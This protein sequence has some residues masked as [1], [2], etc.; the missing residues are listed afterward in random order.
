V[1]KLN[2]LYREELNSTFER[3]FD[4]VKVLASARPLPNIA[5]QKVK[6]ALS[7]E[8]TYN[9]NSI[10][11]N[12][13]SLRET[14]MVLQEG[15]TVKGKSLRE[16]FEAKNHETA[17]DYLYTLVGSTYQLTSK[18]IL[19]LHALVLR[20]IEDDF[21][22]RLRN[23]GVRISGANFV[24]PN[25]NKVSDLLDTLVDFVIT[26]P[27]NLNVI[28]LATFFH[29]KFV[30]IHP[31]FD[32][33]GRTV[34]LAMNLILMQYGFPPAIILKNAR[35]KYYEALNM[36]NNGN[37]SKLMLL[38]CQSLERT[39]NIYLS[40]LPDNT[41]DYKIVSDIVKEPDVPYGQEYISL[42]ARQGKIDAHKEGR[43]WYTTKEAI[44]TYISNRKRER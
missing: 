39:L 37:Y 14:Q 19:S 17:I 43:N 13:L 35:K 32:G 21:A 10:E 9:S 30:W 18:D 11:G 15:V 41:I 40:V 22:G 27:L 38:M 16:H 36:A 20:S 28:E 6:E 26:N 8:W 1:W 34:R 2:T 24:P 25:A 44:L 12:T 5:L 7:I 31:F 42:L 29:H 23:G 3:L 33:N 4:K